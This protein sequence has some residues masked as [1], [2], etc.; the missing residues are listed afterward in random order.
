MPNHIHSIIIITTIHQGVINHAPTLGTIIRTFK[1]VSTRLIRQNNL[2]EFAWQRNYYEHIIRGIWGSDQRGRILGNLNE[3]S[4]D[5]IRKYI[6]ENPL[7]WSDDEEN[8]TNI[9]PT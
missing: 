3:K 9:S 5:D 6:V 1:T 4:L 8:P 2:I 7:R